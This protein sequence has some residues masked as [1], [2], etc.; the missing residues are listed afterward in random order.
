M[1]AGT[2]QNRWEHIPSDC[3]YDLIAGHRRLLKSRKKKKKAPC[4]YCPKALIAKYTA[5]GLNA[6]KVSDKDVARSSA[7]ANILASG[8][9][10][11]G[12]PLI[13][14]SP[15]G[16]ARGDLGS[17]A[18]VAL[19]AR[20]NMS[21][22]GEF[23]DSHDTVIRMGAAPTKGFEN[24][25]GR[26]RSITFLRGACADGNKDK[27]ILGLDEETD[28]FYLAMG[29]WCPESIRKALPNAQKVQAIH[30]SK[31]FWDTLKKWLNVPRH[32]AKFSQTFQT[33]VLATGGMKM[34]ISLVSSGLCTS[35]SAFGFGTGFETYYFD[36]PRFVPKYQ[37][38]GHVRADHSMQMETFAFKVAMRNNQLC[39]FDNEWNPA[40]SKQNC[41]Y[42]GL[43]NEGW[44]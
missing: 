23:I 11:S 34:L 32:A 1:L 16:I 40:V 3:V 39:L 7:F 28:Q 10:P 15:G 42:T 14:L 5:T 38:L 8:K 18:F 43:E 20:L 29:F 25:V 6:R 12:K 31:Y 41:K 26:K 2:G 30:H 13:N 36:S 17:C 37:K 35:V 19:S 44:T 24:L 21:C 9:D 4:K 33:E 27:H 22:Y